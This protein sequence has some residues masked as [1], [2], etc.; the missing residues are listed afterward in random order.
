[1]PL[2]CQALSKWA[3]P[4]AT[5]TPESGKLPT[6]QTP[7]S[8]GGGAVPPEDQIP[9][10]TATPANPAITPIPQATVPPAVPTAAPSSNAVALLREAGY[11]A[12]ILERIE[13]PLTTPSPAATPSAFRG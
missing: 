3:T 11:P 9:P 13:R 1:M 10:P 5:A 6:D 7:Q 8:N 12:A 2:T 4:A